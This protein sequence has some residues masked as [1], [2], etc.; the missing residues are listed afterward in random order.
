MIMT[1]AMRLT[2]MS[3]A[4]AKAWCLSTAAVPVRFTIMGANFPRRRDDG[5]EAR[6]WHLGTALAVGFTVAVVALA[7]LAWLGWVLLGLAGYR[8]HGAPALHDTVGV[9]QLVFA[10]VAGAGALVALIVAYRRQKIAE[11]DSAHDRT[12]VFNE[13][14]TAIAAQLGDAQPAVRLAGVHAMAGLADDWKQNRQTCI[15]VLCAYLRLPYNPDPGD[16]A[17]PAERT[18][19]RAN[20]EVR[21][22]II[23]LIG[24]HL[25]PAA[26]VSWQGLNFD[27]TG[28][29]FDGGDFTAAV[30][31]GGIVLF[32]DAEFSGGQVSFHGAEFS[33]GQVSFHSAKFSGSRVVFD[34]A[35]FSG[36]QVDFGGAEFSGGWVVFNHAKFSDG[37]VDFGYAKF[38]GSLVVF[39]YAK[40]SDGRVDFSGAEFSGRQV[41]FHGAE[42]SGS[43]VDFG[44]AEFSGSQVDFGG[45][46]FSG[47]WVGFNHA[48]F[49]GG[50]VS[51][52]VSFARAVFSGGRVSFGSAKFS[53]SQV[54][55]D[56]AEFSGSQVDFSGA[57]LWSHPPVFGWDGG[58][59]AGVLLPDRRGVLASR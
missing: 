29:V 20:R 4:L 42:F 25:R 12:R 37:R 5:G 52:G 6:L 22:T 28:M 58:P 24:A 10:T 49:F 27:F 9:L 23:R 43:Q 44:G 32:N 11:A 34:L 35:V 8:H 19:Y 30:F 13:R 50:Q 15:D 33:G 46:E 57:G 26:A 1:V 40:F 16:D 18:A 55:F 21:H 56:H 3:L 54:D 39:G 51:F 17:A 31:S 48:K 2:C 14:F 53:G 38:S 59:P 7:G 41:S 36:S 47:G 45:A